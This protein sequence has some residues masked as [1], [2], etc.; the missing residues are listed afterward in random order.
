MKFK[1]QVYTQVS[2]S[3][4]GATYARNRG[5]MYSRGRAMPSNPQTSFQT[6][7]RNATAGL[8]A[9]WSQTLTQDQRDAWGVYAANVPILDRLGD[10]RLISGINWYVRNNVP[11]VQAGLDVVQDASTVFTLPAFTVNSV[12]VDVSSSN[13]AIAFV[14][15]DSWAIEDGGAML[16]YVSRPVSPGIGFFKGPYRYAGAILGDTMTPPTS[17]GTVT[18]PFDV[19]V[20]NKVF[21]KIEVVTADGRLSSPFRG[22][23]VPQP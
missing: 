15:S 22:S 3:V 5:G 2:G 8:T 18:L 9:A 1:S 23:S 20:D 11:R 10:Q 21:F 17:P 13:A 6:V 7:V 12:T 19:T 4:G 14:D 16:V